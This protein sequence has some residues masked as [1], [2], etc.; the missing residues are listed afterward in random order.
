LQFPVEYPGDT[1]G[2]S[3]TSIQII[4]QH[5][6]NYFHIGKQSKPTA[7]ILIGT[8]TTFCSF[9]GRF[10]GVCLLATHHCHDSFFRDIPFIFIIFKMV[11]SYTLPNRNSYDP[12]NPVVE[13]EIDSQIDKEIDFQATAL[14]AHLL[15]D[16]PGKVKPRFFVECIRRSGNVPFYKLASCEGGI[17]LANYRIAV[18]PPV[19]TTT[20]YYTRDAGKSQT[21]KQNLQEG[22][23]FHRKRTTLITL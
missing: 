9:F 22:A 23:I 20:M 6:N 1:I 10:L 12:T 17:E 4:S 19:G 18:A 14:Y 8:H 13:D 3:H 21:I 16:K 7:G 15:V 2:G 11:S 5:F